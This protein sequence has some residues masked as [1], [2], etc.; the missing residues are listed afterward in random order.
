MKVKFTEERKQNISKA[1]KGRKAWNKGLRVKQQIGK[2]LICKKV[3]R[4]YYK[5]NKKAKF[6]SSKCY[7]K[8]RIKQIEFKCDNCNKRCKRSFSE[9]NRTKYHFCSINCQSKHLP[10][11]I[12]KALK[13]KKSPLWQGGK[14]LK[15]R[16]V[17]KSRQ[18]QEWRKKILKRDNYTCQKCGAKRNLE[19]HHKKE[20]RNNIKLIFNLNNG[21]TFCK[22]CH[23]LTDNYANK[24]W[25]YK[26]RSRI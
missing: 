3:F 19:V 13:G 25:R 7:Y 14:T 1:C 24:A 15:I 22:K 4:F 12:S 6:C 8:S 18:Y 10:Y 17:R 21:I 5:E 2:C 23:K 16:T 20:I 11:Q 26:S 9:Y